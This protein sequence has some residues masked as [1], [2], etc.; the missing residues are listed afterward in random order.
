M[1]PNIHCYKLMLVYPNLFS[2]PIPAGGT[3][4]I[5]GIKSFLCFAFLCVTRLSILLVV[6]YGIQS[7]FDILI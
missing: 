2:L 1:T 5:L 7:Y 3:D 6:L 4:T